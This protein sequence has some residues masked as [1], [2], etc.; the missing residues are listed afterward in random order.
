MRTW[1]DLF[2]FRDAGKV[3]ICQYRIE[4]DSNNRVVNTRWDKPEC[5]AFGEKGA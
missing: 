5:E 1:N 2:P 3:A 4:F